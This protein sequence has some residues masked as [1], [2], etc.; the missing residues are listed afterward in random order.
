M[1]MVNARMSRVNRPFKPEQ[2]LD[3]CP[4]NKVKTS[5]WHDANPILLALYSARC[6][7]A[8]LLVP[9]ECRACFALIGPAFVRKHA[10]FGGTPPKAGPQTTEA[11]PSCLRYVG[12]FASVDCTADSVASHHPQSGLSRARKGRSSRGFSTA[13]PMSLLQASLTRRVKS[14]SMQEVCQREAWARIH[15]SSVDDLPRCHIAVGH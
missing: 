13:H 15:S 1:R 5:H 3:G 4:P 10:H 2:C 11:K 6:K 9:V 12:G 7:S 8:R 14:S